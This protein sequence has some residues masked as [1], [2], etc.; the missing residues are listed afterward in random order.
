MVDGTGPYLV[1]ALAKADPPFESAPTIT[2]SFNEAIV[3]NDMNL[4]TLVPGGFWTVNISGASVFT[5]T[6]IHLADDQKTVTLSGN[7]MSDQLIAGDLL[8]VIFH[9][10]S[11]LVVADKA[12]N[13]CTSPTFVAVPVSS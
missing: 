7:W 3:V 12:G 5:L 11:P 8:E 6:T 13:P 4:F 1:S 10:A 2:V 9:P